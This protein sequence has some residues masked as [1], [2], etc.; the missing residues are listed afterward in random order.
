MTGRASEVVSAGPVYEGWPARWAWGAERSLALA[1][2]GA[3]RHR[4][5]SLLLPKVT[6]RVCGTE[7]D[8]GKGI[9]G[10]V[11]WVIGPAD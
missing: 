1:L 4:T 5:R 8:L 11:V 7:P 10:P 3:D 6:Q 9:A 2:P